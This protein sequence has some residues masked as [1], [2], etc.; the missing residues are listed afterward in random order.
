MRTAMENATETVRSGMLY[1][2]EA[3][4]EG[5]GGFPTF[6]GFI[7]AEAPPEWPP[8]QQDA[9]LR[10]LHTELEREELTTLRLG[11]A[12]TRG[13]GTVEFEIQAAESFALPPLEERFGRLQEAWRQIKERP[14]GQKV[15]TLTLNA[16]AIVLDDLWRFRSRLD[17]SVLAREVPNAPP[18]KLQRCFTQT[19]VVSGWNSAHQLPKEDELAIAK[20]AAFLYRTEAE[21]GALLALLR[22]V[23]GQGIGERRAEGF[24]QVIV[25]H[26]F[27][28]EVPKR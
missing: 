9:L 6:S 12:K 7:Q 26:P 24:G 18:F 19:R 3:I 15:F 17:E 25:C 11:A 20:G 16:D 23:E 4:E 21:Q 10:L 27:H 28:W 8:D 1:S 22:Q 13:L 5:G 2:L 14:S